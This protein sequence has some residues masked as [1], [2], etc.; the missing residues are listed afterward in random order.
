MPKNLSLQ[1]VEVI[2]FPRKDIW[3]KLG[4]IITILSLLIA[5]VSTL[6]YIHEINKTPNVF[7]N[8]FSPTPILW[9]TIFE[10]DPIKNISYPLEFDI[11]LE[12]EGDKRSEDSNLN[13]IFNPK[14]NVSL[15]SKEKWSD[16]IGRGM[17]WA[18]NF[19]GTNFPINIK[20]SKNVGVFQLIIPKQNEKIIIAFFILEGDFKRRTGFIYYD[21]KNEGYIV[22]EFS[23][24]K[25]IEIWNNML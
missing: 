21:Y 1:K 13:L 18:F 24:N 22:E 14:I 17:P 6:L 8:I 3:D 5:L 10:F 25:T 19:D 16:N 20:T 2:N 12:N 9:K 7:I 4:V 15:I 11:S 23:V